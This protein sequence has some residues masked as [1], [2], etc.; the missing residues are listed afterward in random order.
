[1]IRSGTNN[2]H[3]DAVP[4]IPT[5]KTIN[6]IDSIAGIQVVDG[7]FSIDSPDLTVKCQQREWEGQD[8]IRS[9]RGLLPRHAMQR[10]AF[11]SRSIFKRGVATKENGTDLR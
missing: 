11:G 5:S 3:T 7:P 10:A 8:K 1:M 2:A 6:D 9:C 4:H